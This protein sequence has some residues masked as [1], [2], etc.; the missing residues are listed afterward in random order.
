MRISDGKGGSA[1]GYYVRNIQLDGQGL[2]SIMTIRQVD[3]KDLTNF[4]CKASNSLGF[5]SALIAIETKGREIKS[6][7][8]NSNM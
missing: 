1:A 2:R 3:S 8:C 5:S 4:T 6:N 7:I